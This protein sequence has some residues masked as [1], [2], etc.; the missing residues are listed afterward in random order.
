MLIAGSWPCAAGDYW[1]SLYRQ[2]LDMKEAACEH[3]ATM[4]QLNNAMDKH[5]LD[6]QRD[7]T[8]R[9]GQLIRGAAG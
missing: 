1:G 3:S 6:V 9:C 2:Q 8:N 5:R 4:L 7:W